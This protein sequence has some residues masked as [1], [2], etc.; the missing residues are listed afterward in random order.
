MSVHTDFENAQPVDGLEFPVVLRFAGLHP[1]ELGRFRMHDERRG[2][3]LTHVDPSATD[4]NEV[5]LAGPKWKEVIQAEVRQARQNNLH[6]QLEA[7]RAKSRKKEA[8]QVAHAGPK[9]PW[10]QSKGG[11]L[12]EGIL[13]VNKDWFGGTGQADWDPDKVAL[14]KKTALAFLR[15][16]FPDGQLRYVSAHA[17]EEAFHIH[18]VV[19]VWRE[20]IT[21]NRGRQILLQ[22]SMNPL[23]SR[24]E[25]AQDLAGMAFADLGLVRG[26]RRAEARRV[27][28]AAGEVVPEK[29]HH[30]PPSKWRA[31]QIEKGTAKAQQIITTATVA[32]DAILEGGRNLATATI[33]KSRKRAIKDTKE[34]KDRAT[35]DL[36]ATERQREV[37]ARKAAQLTADVLTARQE[38][39]VVEAGLA[40][41]QQEF[42]TVLGVLADAKGTL[43]MIEETQIDLLNQMRKTER[44]LFTA[45]LQRDQA[46]ES[47]TVAQA[48][49]A[50]TLARR[51]AEAD[52]LAS[53]RV[54]LR[55][56]QQAQSV[57]E[58]IAQALMEGMELFAEGVFRWLEGKAEDAPRL[59]WG[60]AA[61]TTKEERETLER[62]IKPATPMIQRL[63][64]TVSA[65]VQALLAIERK[66]LA[67]DAAF[68]AGLSDDWEP[69]QQA[70]LDQIQALGGD[71]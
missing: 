49:L 66:T 59:T 15:D 7:L 1:S 48:D 31:H 3:D 60:A 9:D 58:A 51:H 39:A 44:A 37:L 70:R 35:R 8:R 23:L 2:G 28:K 63:A 40:N 26:E 11:P 47:Q 25:H 45:E 54:S 56:A 52:L 27:A 32:A 38:K 29:R 50:A 64:E 69:E 5:L 71:G 22:A 65:A 14:F 55:A 62:R 61:P 21:A 24:Y 19:V 16:H 13:T 67:E 6:E 4:L 46:Q 42:A 12:R 33:Q 41:I 57:A 43:H 36:A 20:R 10:Q 18:F 30:L 34:R 53:T 68:V 17:D